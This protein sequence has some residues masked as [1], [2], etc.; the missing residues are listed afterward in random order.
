MYLLYYAA[1]LGDEAHAG[2]D[3]EQ[4]IL[5]GTCNEGVAS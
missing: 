5:C 1:A 2:L 4:A 3:A